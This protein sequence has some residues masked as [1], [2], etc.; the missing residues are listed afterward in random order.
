[1]RHLT[2][3]ATD[4]LPYKAKAN[5]IAL[6]D[7]IESQSWDSCTRNLYTYT[8]RY[9]FNELLSSNM[10]KDVKLYFSTRGRLGGHSATI[11]LPYTKVIEILTVIKSNQF[12]N[13][14]ILKKILLK[15]QVNKVTK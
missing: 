10:E 14:A 5:I 9:N 12:D 4:N 11:K 6:Q 15:F 8:H 2:A 1:M 13:E 3:T 7:W